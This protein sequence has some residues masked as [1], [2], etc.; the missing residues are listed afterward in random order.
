MKKWRGTVLFVA[1]LVA[2]TSLMLWLLLGGGGGSEDEEVRISVVMYGDTTDRWRSLD[3]GIRQACLELGIEKPILNVADT[4][5]RQLAAIEREVEDGARGVLVAAADSKAMGDAL[6]DLNNDRGVPVVLAE[7]GAGDMLPTVGPDDEALGRQL[8][9]A[10]CTPGAR[11][12]LLRT[13]LERQSVLA[14][15]EAFT[16]R[17]QDLDHEELIILENTGAEKPLSQ[18][19]PAFLAEAKPD[20]LVVLD[21]EMLELAVEAA[22]AAM[23]DVALYGVGASDIAVHALDTG[24]VEVLAGYNEYAI[25][26]IATMQLAQ[27]L[28]LVKDAPAAE[29]EVR[30]VDK[31]SLYLPEVE[32]ILFPITS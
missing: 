25:G 8:A 11:V 29:I 15:Y 32:R 2:F 16:A 12:A 23:V 5:Q 3:Q 10:A 28:G 1:L 22:P 9:E 20:V 26:Y 30:L 13:G 4:P 18:Y 21:N 7:S 14:R 24:A 31:A 27:K 17:A 19:L 6:Q